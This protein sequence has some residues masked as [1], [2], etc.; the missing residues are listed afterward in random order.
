MLTDLVQISRLGRQQ[1]KENQR[2]RAHLKRHQHSDRRLRR[3][4]EEIEDQ[5]DC[6]ACANCCREGEA[7][8]NARDIERLAKF[9]G[10]TRQEFLDGFTMR[11]DDDELILKRTSTGCVF[12]KDNLC[13]VYEARPRSCANYPHLVRGDGSIASRMWFMLERVPYCPIV[14]NWMEA[15]K[16]DIGFR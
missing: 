14:Y 7:G 2:F 10:V 12:L 4:A 16:Q 13:T 11:S 9:I 1:E 15:V 5:I 6:T 3:L 8:V